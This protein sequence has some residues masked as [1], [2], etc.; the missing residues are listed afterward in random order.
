MQHAAAAHGRLRWRC[1]AARRARLLTEDQCA[2]LRDRLSGRAAWSAADEVA[3]ILDGLGVPAAPDEV[4]PQGAPAWTCPVCRGLQ[5]ARGWYCPFKHRYCRK[6]MVQ[7]AEA[8]PLP[9]CPHEGCGYHLGDHDLEDLRADAGRTEALRAARLE[10]GLVALQQD[11]ESQVAVFRCPGSGCSAAVVLGVGEARRRWECSCGAP[12]TCTGCGGSPYHHHAQCGDMQSLRARWLAWLQGGREAYRGLQRRV[13][14][15]A[16]AQTRALREAMARHSELERDEQWKAENCRCCPRCRRPTE[17]IGGCN[18]MVCGQ[19]AH[20][21][22]RQ[23]GC[24]HRFHWGDARPYR[25]AGAPSR[26]PRAPAHAR[27]G[28]ISGRG[29]RHLFA[30]CALCDSG[31]CITGPRFRCVHCLN[32]SCC[33]K[34]EE[35]L[36]TEHEAGHVFEIMFEDEFDWTATGVE[37]PSGTRARIRGGAAPAEGA[38]GGAPAGPGGGSAPGGPPSGGRKRQRDVGAGMEGVVKGRKRGRYVLELAGGMGTRHVEPRDLQPLLTQR[39]ARRGGGE[40]SRG[41]SQQRA[42]GCSA[43]DSTS[44]PVLVLCRCQPPTAAGARMAQCLGA[45]ALAEVVAAAVGRSGCGG[46]GGGGALPPCAAAAAAERMGRAAARADA[47]AAAAPA[48]S[49]GGLARAPAAGSAAAGPRPCGKA[50]RLRGLRRAARRPAALQQA[51]TKEM[52]APFGWD[53]ERPWWEDLLKPPGSATAW[54]SAGCTAVPGLRAPESTTEKLRVADL[55]AREV[56]EAAVH[57]SVG[58]S[59]SSGGHDR[60]L[61]FELNLQELNIGSV[62]DADIDTWTCMVSGPCTITRLPYRS[63]GSGTQSGCCTRDVNDSDVG[64]DPAAGLESDSERVPLEYDVGRVELEQGGFSTDAGYGPDQN[65]ATVQTC[66]SSQQS[67]NGGS[68]QA[69]NGCSSEQQDPDGGSK[70]DQHGGAKQARTS[71]LQAGV[72]GGGA[73]VS[74]WAPPPAARLAT[75]AGAHVFMHVLLLGGL[76]LAISVPS[77]AC[78]FAE[79]EALQRLGGG[80]WLGALFLRDY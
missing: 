38:E 19:N 31:K 22:N 36:A 50:R 39:Q 37:L 58:E 63:D 66:E 40:G 1:L 10:Q 69:Q 8:R 45:T 21:G 52:K 16:G 30:Q 41:G 73:A 48:A 44:G 42:G 65:D 60:T 5:R 34:C 54:S 57:C 24:G 62:L 13:V 2:E 32:F 72:C 67:P 18:T 71:S 14:R 55:L 47:A 74:F 7:W 20:G 46:G 26:A 3:D 70:Q 15:E 49:E 77:M 4:L 23:P 59:D 35:R 79:V 78:P 51:P 53:A 11:P 43:R 27:A 9:T 29:V 64:Y 56:Q 33:L 68:E 6:C 76:A 28:A 17:K 25:A 80:D 75:G 12:S 61:L